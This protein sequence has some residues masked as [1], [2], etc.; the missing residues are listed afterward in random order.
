[1]KKLLTLILLIFVCVSL[2]AGELVAGQ[3]KAEWS[4][5]CDELNAAVRYF[6][7]ITPSQPGGH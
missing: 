4:E 1:M 3:I 7:S 5:F 6:G 2:A